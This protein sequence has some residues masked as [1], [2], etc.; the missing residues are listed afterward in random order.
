[1]EV[2]PY[3]EKSNTHLEFRVDFESCWK[4]LLPWVKTVEK[5]KMFPQPLGHDLGLILSDCSDFFLR[6]VTY[7][8][9]GLC[10]QCIAWY[11]NYGCLWFRFRYCL[12]TVAWV[13]IYTVYISWLLNDDC[14]GSCDGDMYMDRPS[15]FL[16]RDCFQNWGIGIQLLNR[17]LRQMNVSF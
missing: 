9:T 2:E 12:L 15:C 6:R 5:M 13:S 17:W 1:M 7:S 10:V 14:F 3:I 11:W 8:F 4:N 16:C